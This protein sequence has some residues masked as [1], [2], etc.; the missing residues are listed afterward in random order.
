M[1]SYKVQNLTPN[2]VRLLV[3]DATGQHWSL[4]FN[5]QGSTPDAWLTITPETN[6]VPWQV[7]AFGTYA[8]TNIV[9]FDGWTHAQ[10]V[11]RHGVTNQMHWRFENRAPDYNGPFFGAMAGILALGLPFIIVRWFR[12]MSIENV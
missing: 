2:N 12:R 5:S 6:G 10:L 4:V 8:G 1:P 7:Q 11:L 9:S 3:P